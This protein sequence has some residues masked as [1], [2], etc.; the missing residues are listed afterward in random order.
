MKK[1]DKNYLKYKLSILKNSKNFNKINILKSIFQN[2]Y[3]KKKKN[4]K[5]Q[6]I[7][8]YRKKNCLISSNFKINNKKTNFSR[9]INL[10]LIK[11]NKLSNLKIF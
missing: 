10:S 11:K 8:S 1:K 9:H 4:L 7:Y 2:F 6:S 5:L 3:I